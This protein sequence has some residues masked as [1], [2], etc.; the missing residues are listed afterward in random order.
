MVA[1]K[2]RLARPSG[3]GNAIKEQENKE[4]KRKELAI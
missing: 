2:V 3:N 4:K 1:M